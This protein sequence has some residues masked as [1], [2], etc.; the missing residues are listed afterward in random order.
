MS[1]VFHFFLSFLFQFYLISFANQ[2]QFPFPPLLPSN[3]PY[4]SL[5]LNPQRGEDLPERVGPA[6]TWYV[7]LV[8]WKVHSAA[9]ISTSR[10]MH[11]RTHQER[12]LEILATFAGIS[13]H[14]YLL[15]KVPR[16]SS[17]CRSR[18][19]N[20][21]IGQ[22]HATIA[23]ATELDGSCYIPMLIDINNRQF[24]FVY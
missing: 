10:T 13:Y 6:S 12:G 2:F 23:A 14:L 21:W 15:W 7:F 20:W 17:I 5:P 1:I 8:V 4:I 11:D 3:F 9:C 18:A 24:V 16:N 22:T 19:V